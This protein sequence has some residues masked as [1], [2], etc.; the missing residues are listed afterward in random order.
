MPDEL[1]RMVELIHELGLLKRYPRTGWLIAGVGQPESVAEH[2]FR[3][4]VIATLIAAGEG[5]DPQRA[6]FLALLHDT[7]ETR[8]TDLPYLTK[9]YVQRAA[10]N[11][12]ITDEQV[13]GLPDAAARPIREAVAEYERQASLEAR[14]ARDADKLECLV[15]AL[16]YRERGHAGMQG[17]VDSSLAALETATAKRLADTA[18]RMSSLDWLYRYMNGD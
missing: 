18:L 5:A 9:R 11:Q 8:T 1:S 15:Q 13:D 10:P 16:E 3:A 2:S 7:Q 6:A 12:A 17:W 14:C 4:A